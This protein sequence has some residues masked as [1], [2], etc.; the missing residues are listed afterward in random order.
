MGT[1]KPQFSG[2]IDPQVESEIKTHLER[3]GQAKGKLID[4]MWR[5]FNL[6]DLNLL[7]DKLA[8]IFTGEL[9]P[10]QKSWARRVIT[11]LQNALREEKAE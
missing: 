2:Y 6:R 3:S 7:Y 9:T 8:S 10:H 1:E 5:F 4:Q 11:L